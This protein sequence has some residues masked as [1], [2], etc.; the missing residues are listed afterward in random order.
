[1]YGLKNNYEQ[2]S[3]HYDAAYETLWT[4]MD[5]QNMVPCYNGTIVKELTEHHE[6]IK[7]S[8]GVLDKDGDLHKIRYSIAASLT[9][10]VF[11]LGGQLTL[12]KKLAE[13]RNREAL[14]QYGLKALNVLVQRVMRFGLEDVITISL[15]KGQALGAG[16]EAALT[17]DYIIAEEQSMLGFPEILFNLFPGMGA[18]SLVARRAGTKVADEMILGGKVYTAQEALALGVIDEIAKESEGEATV[19]SWIDKN[20]KR[21]NGYLAVQKAKNRVNPITESE[22]VDITMVWLEAAMKLTERDFKMMARFIRSQEKMY[23]PQTTQKEMS[24]VTDIRTKTGTN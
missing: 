12:I 11:N 16:L 10:G 2:V 8:G 4:F 23:L 6:E 9:P 19:Y 14:K 20:K 3:T 22:L 21:S 18:Y 15:L 5:Q 24:N 13:E 17:S 1:M 7:Q